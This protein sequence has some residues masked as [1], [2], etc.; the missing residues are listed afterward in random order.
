VSGHQIV[1]S[2]ARAHFV[3]AMG[4]GNEVAAA[5]EAAGHHPDIDIRWNGHPGR[6]SHSK[7]GL[8]DRD[9]QPAA[10]IQGAHQ[11]TQPT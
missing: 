11:P 1:K 8:T 7:G 3:R 6:S 9:F 2:F 5:A 10:R 4:F